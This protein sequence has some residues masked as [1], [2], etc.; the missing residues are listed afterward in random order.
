M[1]REGSAARARAAAA[2]VNPAAVVLVAGRGV[3]VVASTSFDIEG[4][5]ACGVESEG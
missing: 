4:V 5:R 3:S 2:G 1:L